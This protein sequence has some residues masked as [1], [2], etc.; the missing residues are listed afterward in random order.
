MSE[1][2]TDLTTENVISKCGTC[3]GYTYND[4]YRTI[5]KDLSGMQSNTFQLGK[6]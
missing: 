4:E 6:K 2:R 1:N 3:L 5:T